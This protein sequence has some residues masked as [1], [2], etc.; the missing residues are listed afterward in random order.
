MHHGQGDTLPGLGEIRYLHHVPFWRAVQTSGVRVG[1]DEGGTSYQV[2][3]D[4]YV[5]AHTGTRW[6]YFVVP[7]Y[8]AGVAL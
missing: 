5:Q 4:L 2:S 7:H 1:G 6:Y 3:D 8:Y